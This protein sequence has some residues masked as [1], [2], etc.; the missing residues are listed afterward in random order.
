MIQSNLNFLSKIII[1][2]GTVIKY[3]FLIISHK[4]IYESN[5]E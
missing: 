2:E 1:V 4:E 5:F 3:I